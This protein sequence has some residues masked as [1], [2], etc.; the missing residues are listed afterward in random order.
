MN[1]CKVFVIIIV[2]M[3]LTG[4]V[5]S[6]NEH[7][8]IETVIVAGTNNIDYPHN[9]VYYNNVKYVEPIFLGQYYRY[10]IEND[11]VLYKQNNF[12]MVGTTHVYT[13]EIN[14]PD[15]LFMTFGSSI[16]SNARDIFF[17]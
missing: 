8:N 4:C 15:Y 7:I 12:P 13:K 14:N 16:E 6:V 2:C 9:N 17:R 11:I 1:K 5:P 3:M 10:L